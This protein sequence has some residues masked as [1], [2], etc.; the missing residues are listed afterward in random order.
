MYGSSFWM[1]TLDHAV[2]PAD[3]NAYHNMLAKLKAVKAANGDPPLI[4]TLERHGWDSQA[5]AW[6]RFLTARDKMV[7]AAMMMFQQHQAWRDTT[8]PISLKSPGLQ[9]ILKTKAVSEIDLVID[10]YP[11]TVYVEYAKLLELQA[12]GS[13]TPDD[14]VNAFVIFTERML[15]QGKDPRHPSTCQFIDL[16]GVSV[17]SGFR[18]DTLKLIYHTFEPNYPETLFKMVIYPVSSFT[19]RA[20]KQRKEEVLCGEL[21]YFLVCCHWTPSSLPAFSSRSSAAQSTTAKALLSFVNENTKKK[22]LITN[23][24]EKVCAELGW[25]QTEVEECGGVTEFMHQHETDATLLLDG[26]A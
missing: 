6:G 1:V 15:S 18:V 13:I 19:V 22:F 21:A 25:N 16:S 23:D 17:T 11:P 8:F 2:S 9:Q 24:L 10:H 26:A 5:N 4:L 12:A 7:P 20:Q 14:V 3:G